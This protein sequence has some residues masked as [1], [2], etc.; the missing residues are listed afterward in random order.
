M[1]FVKG[2]KLQAAGDSATPSVTLEIIETGLKDADGFD[3]VKIRF[4]D[5]TEEITAVANLE[6]GISTGMKVVE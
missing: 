5:G 6:Y 1:D 2:M 4:D 3:A